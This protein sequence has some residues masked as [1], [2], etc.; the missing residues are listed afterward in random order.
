MLNNH[1]SE[2]QSELQCLYRINAEWQLHETW[3]AFFGLEK[4]YLS[5]LA[6]KRK[7]N[8]DPCEGKTKTIHLPCLLH[9]G[10][11]SVDLIWFPLPKNA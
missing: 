8:S 1:S 4:I 3:I 11:V 2:T 9:L 10:F 7:S 6:N 5:L